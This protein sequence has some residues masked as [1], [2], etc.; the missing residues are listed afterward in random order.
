MAKSKSSSSKKRNSGKVAKGTK[1]AASKKKPDVPDQLDDK[2]RFSQGMV[3]V[4]GMTKEPFSLPGFSQ[5]AVA[6]SK[7]RVAQGRQLKFATACSGSGAPSLVLQALLPSPVEV[8]S[9]D[10]NPACAHAL[11]LNA[12]PL[13]CHSDLVQ[14]VKHKSCYCYVCNKH[15]PVPTSEAS[16]DLL[17]AG[18]PCNP[19]SLMNK[20]RFKRDATETPDAKVFLGTCDLIQKYQPKIFILENVEGVHRKKGGDADSAD[21]GT[22]AEWILQQLKVRAP[23][24]TVKLIS[25]KSYVLSTT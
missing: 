4:P 14:Q 2:H 15:C 7:C 19:N 24:F 13:H 25:L 16:L 8:M 12:K 20:D 10:V 11:L 23:S 1:Q 22:V 17:I 18:F 3:A 21:T 5:A 9:C 6:A